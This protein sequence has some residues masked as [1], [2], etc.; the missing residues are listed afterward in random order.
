[1][2][3]IQGLNRVVDRIMKTRSWFSA[4]ALPRSGWAEKK[5]DPKKP[6]ATAP[7]K[8]KMSQIMLILQARGITEAFLAA[9][10]RT[11]I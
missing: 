4:T 8:E 9:M 11:R 7:D 3:P 2:P 10:K 1:M 6:A 5:A